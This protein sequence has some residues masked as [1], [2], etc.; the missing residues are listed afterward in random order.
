MTASTCA[1]GTGWSLA[2]PHGR[3][4]GD[5]AR[6]KAAASGTEEAA[7]A[8]NLG[9][10]GT[11]Q[12]MSRKQAHALLCQVPPAKAT[13]PKNIIMSLKTHLPTSMGFA[14]AMLIINSEKLETA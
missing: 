13:H 1:P 14:A 10:S 2:W 7:C 4:H 3:S 6:H 11:Q 5:R 12:G 9:A 8:A